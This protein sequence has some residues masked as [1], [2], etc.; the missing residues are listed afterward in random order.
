ML[1]RLTLS[2]ANIMTRGT[3]KSVWQDEEGTAR[4]VTP[5][6]TFEG[7]AD[8]AFNQIRQQALPAVIIHMADCIGQLLQQAEEGYRAPLERHLRAGRSMPGAAASQPK[9][10]C[11]RWKRRAQAATAQ[12][13]DGRTQ[14]AR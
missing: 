3:A 11:A 12:D 9:K 10:T 7:I 14:A 2:I 13:R 8:A 1:D 6:S 5:V 4:L